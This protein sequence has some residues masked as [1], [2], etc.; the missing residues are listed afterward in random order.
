MLFPPCDSGTK[1]TR[2]IQALMGNMHS[3]TAEYKQGVQRINVD[4]GNED[5]ETPR[6]D[7]AVA[8]RRSAGSSLQRAPRRSIATLGRK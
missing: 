8:S 3:E 1:V 4:N 2:K 5:A 7:V 6:T